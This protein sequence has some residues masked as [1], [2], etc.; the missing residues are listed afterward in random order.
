MYG[1]T[2]AAVSTPAGEGGIAIVRLSGKRALEIGLTAFQ[3][4]REGERFLPK[5]WRVYYGEIVTESH[6]T[7][8][9]CL[10]TYFRCPR[11]F[12]GE[13]LVEFSIHGGGFV[14][15][16]VLE[17]LLSCGAR[18]AEPGEFTRRAF[19]NGRLNLSQAEAVIDVI[20]ATSDVALRNA[21]K[22]LQGALGRE[23]GEARRRL[24]GVM[25]RIEAQLDFPDQ[26]V[27][28]VT[29]A[30]VGDDLSRAALILSTLASTVR[31]GR[32]ARDGLRVV[33]AGRPN[34]GKSSLLN[35][36]AGQERAIVTAV[37]GTTRDTVEVEVNLSGVRVTVVD[38]AGLRESFDPVERLGIERT[39]D[40]MAHADLILVLLDGSEP[41]HDDDSSILK[42]TEQQKRIVL[43][44]KADLSQKAT[45]P[46]GTTA[47]R[48]SARSG[49]GIDALRQQ[50]AA[51]ARQAVGQESLLVT[52]MRHSR[53]LIEAVEHLEAAQ[54]A[55]EAGWDLEL[56]AVDVR[57]A[58]EKLGEITGE[59]VSPDIAQA[60][61]SE[62]CI[63]K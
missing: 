17:R 31:S 15:G 62:F 1:D 16:R 6:D 32:V 63:G 26:D 2:I 49:E 27:P 42:D 21:H 14:A 5:A 30:E 44:T 37:A 19:L 34:V 47:A 59:T 53:A 33:I 20:R 43:L 25:A 56:V 54:S 3:R 50:L 36:L 22:H 35:A 48:I 24:L 46:A 51:A 10:F 45:I 18:L 29:R 39:A 61:F 11:S 28:E 57:R 41:L 60:I 9:E 13:D 52:N 8:D 4:K 7:I 40:A 23:V 58:Y 55:S 38:T 12:T